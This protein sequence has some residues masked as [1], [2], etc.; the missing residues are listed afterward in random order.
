VKA[1]KAEKTAIKENT[2]TYLADLLL[3]LFAAIG[4]APGGSSPTLVQTKT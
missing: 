1:R 3:L 2:E 4:F